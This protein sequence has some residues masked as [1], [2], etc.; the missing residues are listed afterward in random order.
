[1]GTT[2]TPLFVRKQ[3]GG[4][5]AVEDT[6]LSTGNRF[7]VDSATGSDTAGFGSSPD[8]PCATVDYAIG[9]CTANK[10]DII[11]VMPGHAETADAAAKPFDLDVAGVSIIGLGVGDKRPTFTLT[12]A[13]ATCTIGAA[14]CRVSNIRI[15]GNVSDQ[16]VGMTIEA[17]ATG[18]QVDHC[19]F[20][21]SATN[22]DTLIMVSVAADADRLVFCD[23]Q[24][25]GTTGGEATEGVKFAGGCDGLVM[26]RNIIIGDFKTGGCVSL[27]G[28]ASLN[29]TI[30]DNVMVNHDASAGLCIKGHAGMTGSICWNHV[31]GSKANTE[32]INT[33]T[34]AFC[35]E[36]YGNDVAASTGILTPATA[37]SWSA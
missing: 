31:A 6:S 8:T 4:L 21:D 36:N 37:T 3:A 14:G 28:A 11:Y 9:L 1:M 34:A 33:V 23:N 19:Y 12:H 26:C 22:K 27:A 5:F 7:Y 13:D 2:R 18:C 16:K 30:H 32:T 29:V 35:A 20:A 24:I 10:G 15:I 17:A 25:S